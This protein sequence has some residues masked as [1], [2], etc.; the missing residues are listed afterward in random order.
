MPNSADADVVL[1]GNNLALMVAGRELALQ[2]RSVIMLTDSKRPGAHFTGMRIDNY[3]FDIGMVLFEQVMRGEQS[4]DVTGYDDRVRNDSARFAA[5]VAEYVGQFVTTVPVPTPSVWLDGQRHPDFV[6]ANRLDYFASAACRPELAEAVAALP[7]PGVLHASR[8]L[9]PGYQ[10]VS[11]EEASLANHGAPLH[12]L[13]EGLVQKITRRSSRDILAPWHRLAWLPLYYPETLKAALQ[14]EPCGLPEYPFRAAQEGFTGAFVRELQA[15]MLAA[16]VTL[17]ETPLERCEPEA[18]GGLVTTVDGSS[19]RAPVLVMG[20]AQGRAAELLGIGQKPPVGASVRIC[21]GLIPR[22][23]L[24]SLDSCLLVL[25]E[26][27]AIYR[28][29]NQDVAA[30][31]DDPLCR[32]TVELNPQ[33]AEHV[34]P[35][36]DDA[37][38]QNRVFA[39][40]VEFGVISQPEDFRLLRS[41]DASGALPF[42]DQSLLDFS[43]QLGDAAAQ[44][45]GLEL[46]ASLLGMG[47]SSFNDQIIQGLK[48]AR[49]WSH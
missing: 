38:L 29:T 5:V 2:G 30:G 31:T 42:A 8:K 20:L 40:L 23:S 12:A 36:L 17:V 15:S 11:Y 13:F 22:T 18:C 28:V 41:I 35:G 47:V 43:R 25:D 39:E 19:W 37:A 46:T 9:T 16:G 6:I 1:L 14:G 10:W 27:Y 21:F 7:D 26:R 49:T 32:V 33:W 3:D 34:Y 24:L 48:L 45:P 44:W 4:T